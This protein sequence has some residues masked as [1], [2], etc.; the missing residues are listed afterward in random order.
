[1][2]CDKEAGRMRIR[3]TQ[4][5][6][7]ATFV[8]AVVTVVALVAPV[9]PGAAVGPSGHRQWVGSWAASP[10]APTV[11]FGGVSA[12][13]FDHQTLRLV[14]HPHLSGAPLRVR[15]ANTFGH[16]TVALGP[17][18]VGVRDTGAAVVPGTNRVATFGDAR[19]VLIPAGAEVFSDLV[20]VKV[21]AGQDLVVSVYAPA[22]TGPATYH[23]TAQQSNYLAAGDHTKDFGA[24]A[25]TTVL[26][27]WFFLDGI[28]VR[29]AGGTAAV[30]T[31]G[32]SITDGAPGSTFDANH[33]YPDF[34]AQRLLARPDNGLSVLNHGISG[35]RVL[36]DSPCFG[37]S[38]L[39]RLDRDVVA[40]PGART[41]ILLE[42]INDIA[43]S[44]FNAGN[45]PPG[46]PLDCFL[47]NDV[48]SAAQ[49]ISGYQQIIARVHA[50]GLRIL[51][52][53]LTPYQGS[54]PYT[55][56][57]EA[58]RQAVNDWVRTSG[59]FDG[60][61]DFDLALR[62]P[63]NPLRLLP[64]YDSGDHLHPS[65]AGNAA[66]ADTVNLNLL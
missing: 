51:G 31:L 19:T 11:N 35:N 20:D 4:R 18:Y 34:L 23:F 46:V 61:V 17:V 21:R 55:D 12:R 57:G 66:M 29:V 62:D 32:D 54:T 15:L 28:D 1:M 38:A 45:L 41:V 26:T 2:A 3:T 7:R 59:A 42:G 8:V 33:R 43:F 56:A 37:V 44:H 63:A 39:N 5:S 65:D 52:A 25:F 47:P 6:I 60:V 36:N 14:V 53:T 40:Q 27:S 49:I 64:A 16:D 48:V 58:T 22:P 13:G 10:Q 50:A 30:V 9:A 24:A